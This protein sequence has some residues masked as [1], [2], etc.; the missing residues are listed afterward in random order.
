M[1]QFSLKE[2]QPTYVSLET[3]IFHI[4]DFACMIGTLLEKLRELHHRL[5][6]LLLNMIANPYS[7]YFDV[8]QW[9]CNFTN[10]TQ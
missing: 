6:Y 2:Y 5:W 3:F 8:P 7:D 9:E 1:I 4:S 10:T